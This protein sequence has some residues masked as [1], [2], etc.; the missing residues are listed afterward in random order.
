MFR[1]LFESMT[2]MLSLVAIIFPLN[3]YHGARCCAAGLPAKTSS[4]CHV[5]LFHWR[6]CMKKWVLHG[7]KVAGSPL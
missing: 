5:A 2:E 7:G 4:H 3:C 6:M 1:L